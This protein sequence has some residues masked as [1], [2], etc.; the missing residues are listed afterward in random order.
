MGRRKKFAIRAI[1]T[2]VIITLCTATFCTL[3]RKKNPIKGMEKAKVIFYQ[4]PR[5]SVDV[6]FLGS[7][8][9]QNV[10]IPQKLYNIYGITAYNLSTSQQSPI[11]SYYW[12]KEA[13]KTQ[14]PK[15][16]VLDT[17][18][19]P[20]HRSKAAE[21]PHLRTPL[22]NMSWGMVKIEAI[23]KSCKK[24]KQ[25][26]ELSFYLPNIRYHDRWKNLDENDFLFK[27]FVIHNNF[28]GTEILRIKEVVKRQKFQPFKAEKSDA[29]KTEDLDQ[30]AEKIA[31]LCAE[32][33]VELILIK[34][35]SKLWTLRDYYALKNFANKNNL[36]FY[37]MNLDKIYNQLG[38]N[39]NTDLYDSWGHANLQGAIKLT[40]F[41]GK[42]LKEK[43]NLLPHKSKPW[44]AS[45]KAF[46]E[47]NT[48]YKLQT[49]KNL[50]KYLSL[51]KENKERYII[52]IAT[53]GETF[54]YFSK[55]SQKALSELGLT[56]DWNN[57]SRK[58]FCAVI[59]RGRVLLDEMS[60]EKLS[61]TRS[62]SQ[63]HYIYSI[64]SNGTKVSN[65]C[66]IEI[67]HKQEAKN[68][69]GLNIVIFSINRQ[70]VI[71]SVCFDPFNCSR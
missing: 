44:E 32:N 21:E 68:K 2:L 60:T 16:V 15:V 36:P 51:L 31:Q 62:F 6:I 27:E 20:S 55:E 65:K 23:H 22:E 7:S 46:D 10:F 25:L 11:I 9:P 30:Y 48:D 50:N 33:K 64:V 18:C 43:Y 52:F 3:V 28:M 14:K 35:P 19:M 70:M 29:D 66:S 8:H 34:T 41:I 45:K 40:N 24:Y 5:N 67:N 1:I 42:I 61:H 37:D 63:G 71:D 39:Y 26:S 13:M 69:Q 58:N 57:T 4:L 12:L 38:F 53:K 56:V 59:E 49:E 47:A 17:F 54:K